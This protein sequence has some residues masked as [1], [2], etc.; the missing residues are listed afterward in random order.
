MERTCSQS[1]RG[2]TWSDQSEFPRGWQQIVL[3]QWS[4]E[5]LEIMKN[6]KMYKKKK[7]NNKRRREEDLLESTCTIIHACRRRDC[8]PASQPVETRSIVCLTRRWV[9]AY[10]STDVGRIGFRGRQVCRVHQ[11]RSAPHFIS[12]ED[13]RAVRP[14]IFE[15]P[16]PMAAYKP[17]LR[18][19]RAAVILKVRCLATVESTVVLSRC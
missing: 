3:K 14:R 15:T 5:P 16:N 11:F 2:A 10:Q 9:C 8:L 18:E 6:E 7:K 12:R 17:G 13:V 1:I 19:T 4:P